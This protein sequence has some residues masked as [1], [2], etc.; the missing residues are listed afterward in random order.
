MREQTIFGKSDDAE[1]AAGIDWGLAERWDGKSG[2]R[3]D[4][5]VEQYLSRW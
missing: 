5:L 3:D 4:G 2:R 1:L